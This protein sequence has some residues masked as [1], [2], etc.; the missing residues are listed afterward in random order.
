MPLPQP[1]NNE[2]GGLIKCQSSTMRRYLVMHV[3]GSHANAPQ[4]RACTLLRARFVQPLEARPIAPFARSLLPPR[5]C[6]RRIGR[7]SNGAVA[8]LCFLPAFSL[9]F[10]SG[11]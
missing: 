8:S 5:A 9:A 1:I 4:R 10:K 11:L 6:Q 7:G 2:Y 3:V